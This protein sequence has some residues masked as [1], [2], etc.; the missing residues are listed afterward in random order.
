[1]INEDEP[2]DLHAL[3]LQAPQL[4]PVADPA[5][6]KLLK[7]LRVA[8]WVIAALLLAILLKSHTF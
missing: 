8:A 6:L 5:A 4:I 3:G 7:S 1:M 2:V